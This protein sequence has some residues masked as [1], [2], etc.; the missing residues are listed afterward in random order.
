V[1]PGNTDG[2]P[3]TAPVH[4]HD[5]RYRHAMLSALFKTAYPEGGKRCTAV[6]CW[7]MARWRVCAQRVTD[8]KSR[9]RRDEADALRKLMEARRVVSISTVIAAVA[10]AAK[11]KVYKISYDAE[12]YCSLTSSFW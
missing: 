9:P 2:R 8:R 11:I 6:P 4:A 3:G 7:R 5:S 10:S 12:G 1:W